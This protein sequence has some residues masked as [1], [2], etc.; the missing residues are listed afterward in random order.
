L[1]KESGEDIVCFG[2]RR[3]ENWKVFIEKK[4]QEAL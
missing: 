2:W 3:K 1:I 4:L